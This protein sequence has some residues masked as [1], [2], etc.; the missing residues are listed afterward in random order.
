MLNFITDRGL[1]LKGLTPPF[2]ALVGTLVLLHDSV[3]A[4]RVQNVPLVLRKVTLC[5]CCG[6]RPPHKYTKKQ[7]RHH[8]MPLLTCDAQRRAAVAA[9]PVHRRARR[10]QPL[11]HRLSCPPFAAMY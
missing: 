4:L 1:Y 5:S 6:C 7:C 8:L 10:K 11:H 3:L 2:L 9:R